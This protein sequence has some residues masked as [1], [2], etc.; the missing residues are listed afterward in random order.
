MGGFDTLNF[1]IAVFRALEDVS[2][3]GIGV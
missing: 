2:V 3:K 1:S